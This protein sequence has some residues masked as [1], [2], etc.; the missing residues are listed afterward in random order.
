MVVGG[1]RL[2]AEPDDEARPRPAKPSNVNFRR[3]AAPSSSQPGSG[4]SRSAVASVSCNR[5]HPP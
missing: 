2:E 5:L 1:L 4:S 3:I